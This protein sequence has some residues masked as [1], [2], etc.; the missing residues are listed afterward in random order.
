MLAQIAP[1]ATLGILAAALVV[2][3]SRLPILNIAAMTAACAY[4]GSFLSTGDGGMEAGMAVAVAGAIAGLIFFVSGGQLWQR[5]SLRPLLQRLKVRVDNQT[6]DRGR[7]T[8]TDAHTEDRG[9]KTARTPDPEPRTPDPEP[10]T[11]DPGPR[12]PDPGDSL[13][14]R[15]VAVAVLALAAE[16]FSHYVALPIAPQEQR[17][18]IWLALM[19]A[20]AG[21][22]TGNAIVSGS[23]FVILLAAAELVIP[24]VI[25]D[26]ALRPSIYGAISAVI[27][28]AALGFSFAVRLPRHNT[29]T[30]RKD[31]GQA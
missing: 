7:T 5:P 21:L 24:D 19:G 2:A 20:F 17:L 25:S 23:G 1:Y 14:F 22:S 11:P 8:G 27:I 26:P 4:L 30:I 12:I 6:E 31:V 13:A 15:L 3:A 10:R 9:P 16:T 28:F 29:D 18:G